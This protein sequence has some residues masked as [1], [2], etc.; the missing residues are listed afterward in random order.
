MPPFLEEELSAAR[1]APIELFKFVGTYSTYRYTSHD[2]NI[3]NSDGTYESIP[4]SRNAVQAATQ[5]QEELSIEISLPFNNALALEYVF[6]IA[7]P[8]MEVEI[9]RVHPYD[10]ED[11][12]LLW[13]GSVL[14]FTVEDR[15]VRMKVPS[16]LSY[17]LNNPVPPPKYQSPCNWLLYDPVTCG[18]NPTS[19]S[20]TRTVTVVNQTV[21]T[22]DSSAFADNDCAGGE[23]I[24][25]NERRMIVSNVGPIFTVASPF[26][27]ITAGN[28]VV[29]RRG[30]DH[31]FQTCRVKFSNQDR[32]GGFPFVPSRNP[33][34]GRL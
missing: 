22:L 29:V 11:T 31:S 20:A 18:V 17:L 19:N 13:V 28:T 27:Q 1:A 3:S 5:V 32:Y 2:R 21:I 14:S 23:M 4:I 16:V 7:P 9:Y 8:K 10:F 33:F 30:C 34:G 15:I 6:D 26:S 24:V 12:V 25:G